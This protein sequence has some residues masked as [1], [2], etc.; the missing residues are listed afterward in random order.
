MGL[1]LLL[2]LVSRTA[3][4]NC[5]SGWGQFTG[6]VII[7]GIALFSSLASLVGTMTYLF[8]SKKVILL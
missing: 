7:K 8:F 5:C 3:A 1:V 4:L 2:L 6:K